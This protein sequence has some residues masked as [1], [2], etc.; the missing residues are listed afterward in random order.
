MHPGI[1]R[2][3]FLTFEGLDGSGKST[4]LR[5]LAERLEADRGE[6]IVITRQPGG[7]RIGD[8]IRKL[9]LDS[10]TQIAPR[11]ELGLMFSDRAQCIAEVIAPA[12]EQ[13]KIVLCDR[14]TDSTEAYQGGGREL[15]SE[16]VL[17]LHKAICA[18]LEPDLTLLLLPDFD[19][20]LKR[21]RRRNDR[22]TGRGPDENRFERED[23]SFY[24]RV[25]DKYCEIARRDPLRVVVIDGDQGIQKVHERIVEIV[26]ARL[27][28]RR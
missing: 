17:E 8:Q 24:R 4:Q 5:K 14:F 18:G 27:K 13:G 26:K 23:E 9:L 7:T 22:K 15:G 1:S 6:E 19:R 2:G 21:A 25:F 3:F 28:D 16:V 12:L 11:A 20:S 10:R